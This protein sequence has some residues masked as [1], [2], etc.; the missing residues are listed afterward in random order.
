MSEEQ[1][2]EGGER[3]RIVTGN[4]ERGAPVCGE[5]ERGGAER[6]GS[7]GTIGL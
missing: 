4:K 3:E 7:I 2:V 5:K 6:R 1:E